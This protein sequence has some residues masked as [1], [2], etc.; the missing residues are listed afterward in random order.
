MFTYYK[1][2]FGVDGMRFDVSHHTCAQRE[3]L[4]R[5]LN[6]IDVDVDNY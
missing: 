2:Y 4:Q 3:K 6:D 1:S 5:K